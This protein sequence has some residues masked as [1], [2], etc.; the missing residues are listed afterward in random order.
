MKVAMLILNEILALQ[1]GQMV[2]EGDAVAIQAM[3]DLDLMLISQHPRHGALRRLYQHRVTGAFFELSYP[4]PE[5][6]A[7]GPR[8]LVE[9]DDVTPE[10]WLTFP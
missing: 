5:A 4:T 8:R 1:N 6:Y 9:L 2:L 3:L 7:G 10:K